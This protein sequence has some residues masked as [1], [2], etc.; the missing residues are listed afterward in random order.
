M[1]PPRI[2]EAKAIAQRIGAD[3]VIAFAFAFDSDQFGY[4][5]YGQDRARCDRMHRVAERIVKLIDAGVISL[6]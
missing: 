1:K 3:G 6:E 2:T 4:A 5:S